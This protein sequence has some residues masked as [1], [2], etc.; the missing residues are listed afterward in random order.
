MLTPKSNVEVEGFSD[1]AL[2]VN[3]AKDFAMPFVGSVNSDT[4]KEE[5]LSLG[6][7]A[8]GMPFLM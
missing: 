2:Q 1:G 8:Q 5:A 7:Y 3:K 4:S 6:D